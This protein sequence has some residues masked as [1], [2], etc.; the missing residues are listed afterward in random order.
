MSLET[1]EESDSFDKQHNCQNFCFIKGLIAE[2]DYRAS[3]RA[4]GER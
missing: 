1:Q 4:G 3:R 2:G